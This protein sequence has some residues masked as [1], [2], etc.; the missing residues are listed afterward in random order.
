[1]SFKKTEATRY[2]CAAAYLDEKFSEQVIR[3]VI[4]EEYKAIGTS[5]G[6]DL[7]TVVKHCCAAQRGKISRDNW[8]TLLFVLTILL[9]LIPRAL[10][11]F[12]LF[13][14]IA[15]TIVYSHAW[16][17]YYKVVAKFLLMGNF[18]PDAVTPHL[19]E[20]LK[21][22]LQEIASI[23]NSNVIICSGFSPFVGSGS[24][25]GGWS[26]ALNLNQGKEEMGGQI[27]NPLPF[28]IQDLYEQVTKG[29]KGLELKG[30]SIEDRLCVHGRRIRDDRR[31]IPDPFKRP[32]VLVE[33]SLIQAFVENTSQ[34]TTRH[35]KCFRVISWSG[36]LVLSIFLRFSRIGQN[37]FAE[38]SYFLL[39]PLKEEYHMVDKFQLRPTLRQQLELVGQS[40]IKTIFLWP[41][42]PL[43]VFFR[44]LRPSRLANKRRDILRLIRE[45]PTFDYGATN[46]V[47]ETASSSKYQQYFQM[48]DKEMYVKVIEREILNQIINFLDAKNIDT[49]ELKER[50]AAILNNGVIVS[51]GSLSAENLAVGSQSSVLHA[52]SNKAATSAA[53]TD[54]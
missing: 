15:C 14:V 47:R 24:N 11:L 45:D 7:P 27:L 26:F 35:Y 52:I 50:R 8:L 16:T 33:P 19:D 30:L 37:L 32:R 9:I 3:E 12:Y 5:Y 18:D 41:F 48:L 21:N 43:A 51:G 25:I 20:N 34:S 36:E 22:K 17:S 23:E 10:I 46:S 44:I 39:P 6:I 1:M 42:A 13:Y 31:F 28:Q 29:I 53:G 40:A 2:L 54:R 38:A 4:E 49:S